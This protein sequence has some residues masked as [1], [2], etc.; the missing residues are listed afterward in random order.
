MSSLATFSSSPFDAANGF[1]SSASAIFLPTAF[2]ARHRF[3]S[4]RRSARHRAASLTAK[5][6][7]KCHG[8]FSTFSRSRPVIL[9]V[10]LPGDFGGMDG[11]R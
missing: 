3:F 10:I 4:R 8:I 7:G 11:S 2:D 9:V 1:L 5:R 6:R